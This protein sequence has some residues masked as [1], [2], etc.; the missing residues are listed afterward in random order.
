MTSA[1][2]DMVKALVKPGTEITRQ[3]TAEDTHL[4]HMAVGISGE[5]GEL[6]DTIKK[7]VVYQ[8][9]LP[10]EDI[11]EELGD[12]EFYLEGLRQGLGISR[13]DCINA[14][15]SKLRQRY[16]SGEYCDDLAQQRADKQ[17]T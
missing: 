4:L 14:N 12:L 17:N 6:L 7:R 5:S 8:K 15:I 9:P 11:I 3:L 1:H 2:A 16:P 10:L 13:E